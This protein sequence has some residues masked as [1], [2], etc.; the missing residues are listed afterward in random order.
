MGNRI[1]LKH[2]IPE[3]IIEEILCNLPVKSLLRF[4][5]VSKR[6]RFVISSEY[7]I[8]KHLNKSCADGSKHVF[9]FEHRKTHFLSL[10]SC[11]LRD[12]PVVTTN[13]DIQIRPVKKNRIVGS[14]F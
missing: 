10:G 8:K 2:V 5:S 9:G 1:S 3:E 14:L 13:I 7:F 11:S 6:W 12:E 4:K